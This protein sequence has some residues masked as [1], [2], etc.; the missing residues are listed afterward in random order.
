MRKMLACTAQKMS[1]RIRLFKQTSQ[2]IVKK[3][4]LEFKAFEKIENIKN[5]PFFIERGKPKEEQQI[6]TADGKRNRNSP[7]H[8]SS[9]R[10]FAERVNEQR[11]K[12]AKSIMED[13]ERFKS[14]FI[15]KAVIIQQRKKC[16]LQRKLQSANLI[17]RK[18]QH[19]KVLPT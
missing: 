3:R 7:Q 9:N 1:N 6:Q 14:I 5:H 13:K 19:A 16:D 12:N 2:K 4:E 18:R 17:R 8:S 15:F 10:I 11:L